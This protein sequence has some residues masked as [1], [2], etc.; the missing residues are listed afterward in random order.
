MAKKL[1]L[2]RVLSCTLAVLAT[3]AF[4]IACGEG[5]PDNIDIDTSITDASG[6]LLV[7]DKER[8]SQMAQKPSSAVIVSSSSE[9]G[10]GGEDSSDSGGGEESSSSTE[11]PQEPSSASLPSS[12]SSET[13]PEELPYRVECKVKVSTGADGKAIPQ[14]DWPEVK[15]ID[16]ATN[17]SIGVLVPNNDFKF[18]DNPNWKDPIAGT[19]ASIKV[20]V[21]YGNDAG[22][23]PQ[24]QACQRLKANCEG[25][26]TIAKGSSSSVYIPP[27]Q[28]SSSSR[29][30]NTPSSSSTPPPVTPSSSSVASSGGG[31]TAANENK[32][33]FYGPG[34]CHKMPTGDC[35]ENGTLYNSCSDAPSSVQ[36]CNYGE[37]KGGDGW[38][39]KD[40]GG[41]YP[42]S[43]SNCKSGDGGTVVSSCPAGTKPPSANY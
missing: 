17:A 5:T 38:N 10:S 8:L 1:R 27:I 16:K 43:D 15:C 12:S 14:S 23:T 21:F 6:W 7:N 31:C 20:E 18:I 13:P 35:C 4:I 37:C 29:G 3:V 11:V 33:C 26:I 42:K 34:N 25:S 40:G 2:C 22:E 19:Y 32:Y 41:C 30:N 28:P 39:C 36:Y 9:D 24:A